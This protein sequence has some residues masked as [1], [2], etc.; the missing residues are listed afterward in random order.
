[1]S[2]CDQ[3]LALDS[4]N[5]AATELKGRARAEATKPP[6]LVIR[7]RLDGRE[8]QGARI[9]TMQ[10]LFGLPYTWDE[11]ENATLT[12]GKSLSYEVEYQSGGNTYSGRL[13]AT[14][15]W[16]GLKTLWVELKPG[17]RSLRPKPKGIG[18][19]AF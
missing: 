5:A 10:G 9:R 19:W 16:H 8:V 7:A 12:E 18:R 3:V 4:A 11:R 6:Q 2:V 15:N 1:M 13:E 14:V 17:T